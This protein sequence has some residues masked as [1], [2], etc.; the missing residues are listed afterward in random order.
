MYFGGSGA[1]MPAI[2]LAVMVWCLFAGA[3]GVSWSACRENGP[4]REGEGGSVPAS[5]WIQA[6]AFLSGTTEA[7][8][9]DSHT[10]EQFMSLLR[11]PLRINY[12]TRSRLTESGLFSPYQTASLTDYIS[13]NGDVLSVAELAAVDGFGREYA[14]ALAYF[15]SF[16]SA[17][18]PGYSSSARRRLLN[19]LTLRSGFR[20]KENE[21]HDC[22]YALRYCLDLS[23]KAELGFVAKSGYGAGHFPPEVTSFSL[24]FYGRGRVGKIVAGDFNARF[25]QG[26]A[27]WSGFSMGGL[28][29]P[30]SYSRRPS[31]ISPYRSYS[32]EGSFRGLAADFSFGRFTLSSFIAAEGLREVFAGKIPGE[33]LSFIP[34]V[35]MGYYGRNGQVSLTCYAQTAPVSAASAG[36]PLADLKCSADIR[37]NIR[38]TDFFSEVAVD[39]ISLAVAALAGT[40]FPIG[41]H[42]TMAVSA[43]YYPAGYSALRSGAVRSGTKCTNEYGLSASG[44]FAAGEYVPI[45][46]KTGFGSSVVRHRGVFGIDASHAPAP[47]FGTDGPS[48]QMKVRLDYDCRVSPHLE[49]SFRISE[50]IRTWGERCKTDLRADVKYASGIFSLVSRLSAVRCRGTGLLAY[51]EGGCRKG[52]LTLYLR[53]GL[54]RVDNWDD[55][56]YVYERDAPGN[57]NVPAYYGRGFWTAMTAGVK[58]SRSCRAY[59]R[60]SY[61]DYPWQ[62]PGTEEKK[63]GKAELKLQVVLDF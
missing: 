2:R 27:L 15:V 53:G 26:L 16:E 35:N 30:E 42:L 43:R 36:N 28:S 45:A 22:S 48:S 13:R 55:R 7:E 33:G 4:G 41:E 49:L 8:E 63:P 62:T 40:R 21:R 46:G 34:A 57:F 17:A 47:R 5:G 24:A 32:G 50:R 12:S 56:I 52:V 29:A 25:G 14:A 38:G 51:L 54:F 20:Q 10:A 18:L 3:A 39:G 19:S 37:W 1:R 31:G 59:L 61:L 11:H 44:A 9:M 58:C 6:M 23:G 60:A